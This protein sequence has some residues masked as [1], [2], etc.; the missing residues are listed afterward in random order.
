MKV[1]WGVASISKTDN[2]HLLAQ[3]EGEDWPTWELNTLDGK[4]NVHGEV[5]VNSLHLLAIC[6]D[7]SVLS[8]LCSSHLRH[9][10]PADAVSVPG[11]DSVA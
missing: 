3:L 2:L 10:E 1:W 9:N 4:A 5:P 11:A 8:S 6:Q 7:T